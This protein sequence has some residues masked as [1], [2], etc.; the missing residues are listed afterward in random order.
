MP[1]FPP[2][3]ATG[4]PPAD[5]RMVVEATA[6]RLRTAAPWRDLPERL[7]SWNTIYRNFNRWSVNR[8]WARVMEQVQAIA[9][10][11]DELDWVVSIEPTNVRVHQHGATLPRDAEG[12]NELQEVRS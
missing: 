1:L 12:R 11:Q 8:V 3:K 7:G 6:W 9:H 4:R 2:V 10:G 5:R